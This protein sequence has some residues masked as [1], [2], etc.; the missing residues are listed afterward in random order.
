MHYVSRRL[1]VTVAALLA[2]S[3]ALV[4][5]QAQ[6]A[7]APKVI[8][9]GY[10]VLPADTF[11]DGPASGKDIDPKT[12]NGRSVPF[13]SHPVQG[14][15]AILPAG[16]GKF[17]I[18]SDNGYGAKANS[19]DYN[20]RFY[21]VSVNFATG[22]VEVGTFTQLSDPGKKV[23]FTIVNNDAKDRILT[24]GDFDIES[25]RLAPDG[26]YW[27]GEE[28]GPYL[29]H[30]D[31]DG[32]LLEAP[33]PTPYPDV[34]KPF[35]KTLPF[36]QSPDHPDFVSLA[37]QKARQDAANLPS[38]RGFEGMALNTSGTFLYPLLEGGLI[39]DTVKTRLL[40]QEFDLQ[41]KKYTGKFFFYPI[42]D[43]AHAIGEMT[44][45]NDNEYLVIE[46]DGKQGT[47]A[48]FKRIYKVD[49]SQ[50]GQDGMLTKTLV[51]DLM[52]IDDAK[53]LTTAQDGVVGYGPTFT[54]PFVTI[55]AVYPLAADT[56]IVTN[57]NNYPFSLGR[58]TNQPDD[59]EIILLRL[60]DKL[61][62]ATR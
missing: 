49:F 32:R 1:F 27:F 8:L 35:A 36:I 57:D 12:T 62:L 34:L 46:R 26:T 16:E 33:I 5:V 22:K 31:K 53:G 43:A 23:P 51:V 39:A 42:S 10:A 13:K 2:L 7:P 41:A 9:E 38:S 48:R 11:A 47:E 17:L 55:E 14:I 6:E 15:S 58:R 52:K 61:H 29:L 21:E 3:S 56:L 28:F 59:N 54:F 37:D 60:A 30:V 40:I 50:A 25:F 19:A 45:I 4:A 20:L 24:G 44:A 18:M